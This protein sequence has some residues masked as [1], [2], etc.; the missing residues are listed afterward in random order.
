[1]YLDAAIRQHS[2]IGVT[3]TG[4]NLDPRFGDQRDV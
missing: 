2:H 1:M 3:A 4:V